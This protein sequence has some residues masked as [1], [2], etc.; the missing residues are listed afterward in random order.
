MS[1]VVLQG[2]YDPQCTNTTRQDVDK[3]LG[4]GT[5]I[6]TR[7]SCDVDGYRSRGDDCIVD[8]LLVP[9]FF[10]VSIE[11]HSYCCYSEKKNL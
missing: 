1:G 7:R 4:V 5:R 6:C 2:S 11:E 8:V 3:L 9:D 10:V